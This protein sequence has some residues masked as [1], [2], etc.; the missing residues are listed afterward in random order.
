MKPIVKRSLIGLGVL[1]VGAQFIRPD[2]SNPPVDP[3]RTLHAQMDVP[4]DVLALIEDSCTDCHTHGTEWPWYSHV[5]PISWLLDYHVEHGREYVDFDEWAGYSA[6][7]QQQALDEIAEVVESGEMPLSMYLPLHPEAQLTDA[8]RQRIV[9]WATSA[10]DS[11]LSTLD[12]GEIREGEEEG[13]HEG[14]DH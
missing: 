3:S 8:E 9:S 13:L 1:F 12:Q 5:A 2:H 6:Y 7:E 10:R 11:I 14:H 4:S